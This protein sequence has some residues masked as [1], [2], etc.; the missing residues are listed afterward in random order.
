LTNFGGGTDSSKLNSGVA[1][2]G[3]VVVRAVV[4]GPAVVDEAVVVEVAGF[5]VAV[6][7]VALVAVGGGRA[8]VVEPL[9]APTITA[10]IAATTTPSARFPTARTLGARCKMNE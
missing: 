2:V 7:T 9:H 3:E 1:A 8:A 6:F 5:V 10:T 4:L